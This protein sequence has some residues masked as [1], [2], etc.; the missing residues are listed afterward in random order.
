MAS[1]AQ[2]QDKTGDSEI[3]SEIS[4][5]F[6]SLF[7][8]TLNMLS[9][10]FPH[11]KGDGSVNEKEYLAMRS[12]VLRCGNDKLRQLP[13][14]IGNYNFEKSTIVEKINVGT[15]VRRQ[16]EATIAGPKLV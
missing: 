16:H 1:N 2:T 7:S 3:V 8:D 4:G 12:R 15:P 9:M 13:K 5:L 14:I 11:S 10:R 6:H